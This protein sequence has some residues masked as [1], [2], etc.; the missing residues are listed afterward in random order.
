MYKFTGMIQSSEQ[1]ELK[2]K[3]LSVNVQHYLHNYYSKITTIYKVLLF[4][5]YFILLIFFW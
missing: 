4:F 1:N 3:L 5:L 2:R